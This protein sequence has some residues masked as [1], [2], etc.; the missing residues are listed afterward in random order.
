MTAAH[1][2]TTL[3]ISGMTC[4]H[5]AQHVE[6]ALAAVPDVT[7]SVDLDTATAEVH[8]DST[9]PLMAVIEAVQGA[10]YTARTR[11]QRFQ[12]GVPSTSP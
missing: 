11:A 7:A 10:G 4:S 8:H 9:V 2:T 3:V 5:C 12:Y 6:S 1:V